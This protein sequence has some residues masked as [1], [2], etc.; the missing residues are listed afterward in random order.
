VNRNLRFEARLTGLYDIPLTAV[1]L[2]APY[3]EKATKLPGLCS[4][5][6]WI[7]GYYLP[8]IEEKHGIWLYVTFVRMFV[9]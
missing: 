9:Y 2:D 7:P 3:S 5:R 6:P 1:G 4:L 8:I